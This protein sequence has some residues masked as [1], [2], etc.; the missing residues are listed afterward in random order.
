MQRAPNRPRQA[1]LK[2]QRPSAL[3]R[4][5]APLLP[6]HRT[7]AQARDGLAQLRLERPA[8][9]RGQLQVQHL[10][11]VKLQ[12][13]LVANLPQP[14]GRVVEPE[15]APVLD[16][17]RRGGDE[18]EAQPLGGRVQLGPRHQQAADAAARVPLLDRA[19]E[20]LGVP[21]RRGAF[22]CQQQRPRRSEG[23]RFGVSCV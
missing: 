17:V 11:V 9:G 5:S 6:P 8:A 15:A 20:E 2:S 12:L 4:A 10:R 13:E 23:A 3:L 18:E 19:R 1:S 7:C 22:V 14:G 16:D 21:A